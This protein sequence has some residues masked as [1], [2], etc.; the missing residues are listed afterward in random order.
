MRKV[1]QVRQD[2]QKIIFDL[3]GSGRK[4]QKMFRDKDTKT[5]CFYASPNYIFVELYD[6]G[7]VICIQGETVMQFESVD[8]M[9][10]RRYLYR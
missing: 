7:S 3:F 9:I 6:D 4:I 1:N 10:K 8:K 2:C 5:I